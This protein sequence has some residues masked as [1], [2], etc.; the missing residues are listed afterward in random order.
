ML[1][2]RTK[3]SS[4]HRPARESSDVSNGS[5]RNSS[6]GRP[7]NVELLFG[8]YQTPQFR[9]G[10][11]VFCERRG[12]VRLCG[13]SAGRIPWPIGQR[14][15]HEALVLYADLAKAVRRE[16][17]TAIRY[18]W[19]VGSNTVWEWR[20]TLGIHHANDG[21]RQLW[22]DNAASPVIRAAFRKVQHNSCQPESRAKIAAAQR[23][24]KPSPQCVAA[25]I[26]AHLGK[27][28]SAGRVQNAGCDDRHGSG[29]SR[30]PA[31]FRCRSNSSR[32]TPC[33]PR[34]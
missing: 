3:L 30:E 29:G 23:G 9:H 1:R 8:P 17:A 14:G 24:R 31:R 11:I 28:A 32:K 12:E 7:G 20:C 16:S 18:W 22:R 19:G 4:R 6:M 33:R 26:R 13:L 5:R 27:R 25:S 21:S 2:T 15:N 10:D 34:E